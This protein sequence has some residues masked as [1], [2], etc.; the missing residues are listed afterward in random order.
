MELVRRVLVDTED[1]QQWVKAEDY[2]GDKR[3]YK[4]QLHFVP[5]EGYIFISNDSGE[6]KE[7]LIFNIDD[8]HDYQEKMRDDFIPEDSN[9]D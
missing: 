8:P 1:G 9:Q 3:P 2:M 6:E 5:K 4:M 7:Y